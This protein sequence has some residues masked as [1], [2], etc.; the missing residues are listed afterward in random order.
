M[1]NDL[2]KTI[3]RCAKKAQRDYEAITGGQWLDHAPELFLQAE[4]A[5]GI[6]RRGFRVFIDASLERIRQEIGSSKGRRPAASRKRFDISV[7]RK[8]SNSLRAVIE[9][10]RDWS[11]SSIRE[12]ARKIKDSF[13]LA[14]SA[15]TGYLL[16]YS[17]AN[18]ERTTRR[19]SAD[20]EANR[21]RILR[22]RFVD[23][24]RKLQW[25]LVDVVTGSYKT[26]HWGLAL[27]R[28]DNRRKRK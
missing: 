12:D 14:N 15:P 8:T 2:E 19:R 16:V 13:K 10:K 5:R 6:W 9:I 17:E 24:A 21:E 18:R 20:W 3:L 11:I 27:L 4:V 28:L 26:D 7:W 1:P 23:W 22:K 25:N